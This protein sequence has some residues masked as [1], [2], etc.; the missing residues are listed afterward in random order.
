MIGTW[1]K[2]I[3]VLYD[4]QSAMRQ[5]FKTPSKGLV[6]ASV[7]E[8]LHY[9]D[10]VTYAWKENGSSKNVPNQLEILIIRDQVRIS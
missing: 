9:C 2:L 3:I 5:A 8:S 1:Q 6:V 4:D 10:Q 7:K